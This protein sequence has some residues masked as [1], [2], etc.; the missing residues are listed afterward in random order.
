M[1]SAVAAMGTA[2]AS[3][4]VVRAVGERYGLVALEVVGVMPRGLANHA[5]RVAS[6]GRAYVLRH[7]RPG[8][9]LERRPTAHHALMTHLA[10]AGLPVPA[11][12][13]TVTGE[14]IARVDGVAFDLYPFVDGTQ[15]ALGSARHV[16]LAGA[17]LA[18]LHVAAESC[19]QP[20]PAAEPDFRTR[21][22]AALADAPAWDADLLP[23]V[24]DVRARLAALDY[25]ALPPAVVHGDFKRPN[26][27]FAGDRLAGIVD[28][29]HA[30]RERRAVDLALGVSHL[31]RGAGKRAVVDPALAQTFA[32]AYERVAPL[33][34]EERAALPVLVLAE[35]CRAV[36]DRRRRLTRA[37]LDGRAKARAKVAK[38]AE[39][40]MWLHAHEATWGSALV[41]R[42]NGRRR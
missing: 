20:L 27:L 34:A 42:A 22:G 7:G 25:A 4:A 24:G 6:A 13:R 8:Q 1:S 10:R 30:C 16:A 32:A 18:R 40:L 33:D 12:L 37:P 26:L 2:P 19:P 28:F 38:H 41:R 23:V 5:L 21:V 14:T 29:D 9:E 15:F 17:A 36:A 3:P 11:P 31:A 35:G 39:R